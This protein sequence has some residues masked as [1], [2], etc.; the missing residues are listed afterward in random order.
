ML[1]LPDLNLSLNTFVFKTQRPFYLVIICRFTI[2]C[3]QKQKRQQ[4]RRLKKIVSK[5]VLDHSHVLVLFFFS[6]LLYWTGLTWVTS[7]ILWKWQGIA[8]WLLHKSHASFH[9]ALSW[10]NCSG[11]ARRHIAKT[12]TQPYI[13]SHVIK[14][15]GGQ[16]PAPIC[17]SCE[18]ATMA[19]NL[20]PLLMH[21]GDFTWQHCDCNLTENLEPEPSTSTTPISLTIILCE[22]NHVDFY[23][24]TMFWSGFLCS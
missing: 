14:I 12:V 18:Q 1:L 2:I 23:Y 20:V 6:P 7:Q 4:K 11:E 15:Y 5:I 10:I 8:S 9:L 16:Q 21:W 24:D 22:K 13:K 3:F 19:T 17:R